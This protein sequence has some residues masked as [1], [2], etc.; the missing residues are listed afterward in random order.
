LKQF[1]F[2]HLDDHAK[3]PLALR[4]RTEKLETSACSQNREREG[5]EP[6]SGPGAAAAIPGPVRVMLISKA[7][8]RGRSTSRVSQGMVDNGE[9]ERAA[10]GKDTFFPYQKWCS[11][12]GGP[13][14]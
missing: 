2:P 9:A 5:L 3:K 13:G 10:K 6:L 4:K 1:S 7:T 8:A 11:R 12:R 14:S